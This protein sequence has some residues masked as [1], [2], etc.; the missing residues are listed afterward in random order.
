MADQKTESEE[1]YSLAIEDVCKSIFRLMDRD[2]RS[3]LLVTLREYSDYLYRDKK[4]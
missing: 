2:E 1:G 3:D 4:Y